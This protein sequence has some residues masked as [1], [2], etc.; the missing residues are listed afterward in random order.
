MI[1]LLGY[2]KHVGVLDVRIEINFI[3]ALCTKNFIIIQIKI[4][5]FDKIYIKKG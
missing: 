1:R 4:G 2:R 3:V 5:Y